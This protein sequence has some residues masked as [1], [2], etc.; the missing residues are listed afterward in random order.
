MGPRPVS[1]SA[2]NLHAATTIDGRDRKRLERLCRYLLRPP[3]AQDAIQRLEHGRVRLHLPRRGTHLDM[4]GHQF[5]AK[6]IAHRPEFRWFGT[7]HQTA[8]SLR[9]GAKGASS[10]TP[11]SCESGSCPSPSCSKRNSCRCSLPRGSRGH[12]STRDSMTDPGASPGRSCSLG[13]SPSTSRPAPAAVAACA[14]PRP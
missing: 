13:S 3:F 7:I 8:H 1:T 14:S 11:V 10:R 2:A 5:L 6:L 4:S 9:S 12:R